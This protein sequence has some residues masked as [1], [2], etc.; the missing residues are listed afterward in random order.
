MMTIMAV[1]HGLMRPPDEISRVYEGIAIDTPLAAL[2]DELEAHY[3]RRS[4]LSASA[5]LITESDSGDRKIWIDSFVT[6]SWH[7]YVIVIYYDPGTLVVVKK[8]LYSANAL[9]LSLVE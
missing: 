2:S 8:G 3:C 5:L 9:S 6:F 7:G 1:I 4:C